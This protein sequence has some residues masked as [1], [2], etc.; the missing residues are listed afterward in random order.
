M[1]RNK[2]LRIYARNNEYTIIFKLKRKNILH[3]NKKGDIICVRW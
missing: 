1:K 2:I 3:K